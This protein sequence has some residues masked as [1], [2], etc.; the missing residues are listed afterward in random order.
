[1][2][3]ALDRPSRIIRRA[4]VHDPKTDCRCD[5]A[6]SSL[7]FMD[8]DRNLSSRV[9]M[10]AKILWIVLLLCLACVCGAR[11]QTAPVDEVE[12]LKEKMTELSKQQQYAEAVQVGERLIML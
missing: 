8:L 9:L 7:S 3:T 10:S 2:R 11:G 6:R 12:H 1:M 4:Q 5:W